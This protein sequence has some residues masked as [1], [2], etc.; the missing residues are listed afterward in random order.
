MRC[1]Q[2]STCTS[3]QKPLT[4]VE[5]H[6]LRSRFTHLVCGWAAARKIEA[7]TFVGL[8]V[9]IHTCL[10]LHTLW[11]VWTHSHIEICL[12]GNTLLFV[13]PCM[14]VTPR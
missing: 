2:P 13:R 4:A 5:L 1:N 7:G 14:A 3:C 10:S 12:N 11:Y 9:V 8:V 6:R